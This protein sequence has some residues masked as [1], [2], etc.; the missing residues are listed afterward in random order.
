MAIK[1]IG[2]LKNMK[3][4]KILIISDFQAKGG[5][6]LQLIDMV[7]ELKNLGVE[8]YAWIWPISS[9]IERYPL[10]V[11]VAGLTPA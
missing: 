6:Y 10:K 5:A 9:T 2:A 4:Y 11:C 7:E 1:L 3:R 8:I